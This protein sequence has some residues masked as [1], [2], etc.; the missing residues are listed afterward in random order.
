MNSIIYYEKAKDLEE[1]YTVLARWCAKDRG[2]FGR[3]LFL[4]DEWKEFVKMTPHIKKVKLKSN[5]TIDTR[6][7]KC[8]D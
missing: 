2:C 6:R 5:E 4:L 8:A 3:V 1:N 7:Q